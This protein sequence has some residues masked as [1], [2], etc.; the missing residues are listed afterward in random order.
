MAS[1]KIL[2]KSTKNNYA[3][4]FFL[5]KLQAETYL[6]NKTYYHLSAGY[7]NSWFQIQVFQYFSL[8]S[9][10]FDRINSVFVHVL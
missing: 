3:G 7:K 9:K 6:L 2:K 8:I 5:V 10:Y 4:V 1:L